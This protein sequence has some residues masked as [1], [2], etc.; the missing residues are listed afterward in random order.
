M[1]NGD[2]DA[3]LYIHIFPN[4]TIAREVDICGGTA[5]MKETRKPKPK[6][7]LVRAFERLVLPF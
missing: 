1:N 3:T 4:Q 2:Y 6:D 5:P 7:K